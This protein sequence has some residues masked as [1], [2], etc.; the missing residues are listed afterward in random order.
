MCTAQNEVSTYARW[1]LEYRK[2]NSNSFGETMASERLPQESEAQRIGHRADK[3]FAA[4]QPDSW[5]AKPTD[6][7]DDVGLDYQVQLVDDGQYVGLFHVQLKGSESPTLNATGEF[8]SIPLER[9]TVNYDLRISEPVLLVFADLSVN[10]NTF[11][12]SRILR[13]DNDD[14]KRREREGRSESSSDTIAF[15]VPVASRL[16]K[17]LGP[18]EPADVHVGSQCTTVALRIAQGDGNS[19]KADFRVSLIARQL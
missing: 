8:Y 5:R 7:T 6:G 4:N 10:S 19:A 16:G 13:L 12:M 14:L 1:D 11:E 15:R 9:S 17:P 18:V 2:T 3:C